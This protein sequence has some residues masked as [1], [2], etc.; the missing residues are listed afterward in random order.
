[1]A[2]H[3]AK[4]CAAVNGCTVQKKPGEGS[5]I[6][7]SGYYLKCFINLLAPGPNCTLKGSQ[8][9]REGNLSGDRI[10]RGLKNSS[11]R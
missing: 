8:R 3:P 2:Q 6:S 9:E 4:R 1:M 10:F 7:Y 11:Y 5:E